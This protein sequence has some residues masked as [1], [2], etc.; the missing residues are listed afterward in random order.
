M[1]IPGPFILTA[2]RSS[3]P[4]ADGKLALP[5]IVTI[6]L[7]SRQLWKYTEKGR[8]AMKFEIIYSTTTDSI[9]SGRKLQ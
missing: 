5:Q 2:L 6:H 7:V 3:R 4:E 1:L 9:A 8:W